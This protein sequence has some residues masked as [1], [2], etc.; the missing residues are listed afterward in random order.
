MT[1]VSC[2]KEYWIL[3]ATAGGKII[4]MDQQSNSVVSEYTNN[5]GN[6][7]F[8]LPGLTSQICLLLVM[9]LEKCTYSRFTNYSM[10]K[11]NW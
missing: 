2:S 3:V 11:L 1:A 9:T 7:Y 4:L 5:E 6:V 10:F 8:V